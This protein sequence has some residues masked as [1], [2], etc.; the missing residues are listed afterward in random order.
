MTTS[1]QL[2][3]LAADY[4][5]AYLERNPTYATAIGDRRFEELGLS[6]EVVVEGAKPDIGL[7]RVRGQCVSQSFARTSTAV[8]ARI[9]AVS[10]A[11]PQPRT[12]R[13]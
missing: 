11:N 7:A 13:R 4:W 12:P 9:T 6:G 5:D 1:E 10:N 8:I 2:D 3:R